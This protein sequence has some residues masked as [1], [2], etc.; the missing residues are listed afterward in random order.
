MFEHEIFDAYEFDKIP[1]DTDI[2][3]RDE[4]EI[5]EY[6]ASLLKVHSGGEWAPVGLVTYAAARRINKSS[7]ELSW[8]PNIFDRFHELSIVLPR[9]QFVTC[10][11]CWNQDEKPSIFVKTEWLKNLY[12]R[13]YS[14]FG[15]IDAIGIKSA[16]N[17]G[18]LTRRRLQ[19][20]RNRMDKLASRYSKIS[21]ISFADSV[22]IK[23]NWTVGHF[24]IGTKYTYE[25][26]IFIRLFK[27]I[28]T[29]YREVLQLDIY[30]IFTQGSN[31]Y[32][33]NYLL[34]ISKTKNHICLNSL[35]IPFAELLAIDQAARDAI[36]RAVHLPHEIYMDAQYFNSLRLDFESRRKGCNH[37]QY[38]SKMNP[39][40]VKKYFY[41]SCDELLSKLG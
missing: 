3:L 37:S 33:E 36:K 29:I 14:V 38:I 19:S 8:Y 31:E 41:C 15:L 25:P 21:F 4:T 39:E 35:G 23:S 27:E 20:L 6:E 18:A 9:N 40:T 26:E 34:H 28:K 12:L 17:T 10:V 30:G 24:K 16:I 13:S 7:L 32:Y 22:L 2:Y 5:D 11:G 1:L